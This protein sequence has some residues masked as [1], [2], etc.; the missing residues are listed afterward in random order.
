MHFSYIASIS[1]LASVASSLTLVNVVSQLP[2]CSLSCLTKAIS[3]AG[4]GLTDYACQ[5]GLAKSAIATVVGPCLVKACS[6]SDVLS[7]LHHVL[8]QVNKAL[9]PDRGSKHHQRYLSHSGRITA[10]SNTCCSTSTSPHRIA[11]RDYRTRRQCDWKL[12]LT[13]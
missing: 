1:L 5:C 4:C 9:I 12:H 8:N 3:G 7:M 2:S 10:S 6:A 11:R 13:S